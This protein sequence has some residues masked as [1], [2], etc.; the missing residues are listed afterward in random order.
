MKRTFQ[1]LFIFGVICATVTVSWSDIS[2][3]FAV[4]KVGTGLGAN[5][6]GDI[7]W[8][9]KTLW[10][11]GSG[12]LT[13]LIG[14]GHSVY[15]WLSYEGQ[16]GFGKGSIGALST[17]GDTLVASWVFNDVRGGESLVSGDGLSIS[18]DRGVTWRHVPVIELFPE[19]SDY[20]YPGTF[21]MTYDLE[22]VNGILWVASTSG[23]LFKTG[24]M[25]LTWTKVMPDT[26][27]LEFSNVN[28]HG[29]S[30]DVYG[31]TLWV[32]T[33]M[34]VNRSFDKGKTWTNYSWPR[35]TT[36]NP[37]PDKIWPG[38]WVYTI[39]HK[40]VNGKTHVWTSSEIETAKYGL[41]R[42]GICHTD[43]NGET[44]EY[45]STIYNAW[46]FAF[47]HDGANNPKISDET[48]IA[49]TDSG[50]VISYDLGENWKIIDISESE[51]KVWERGTQVS[52]VLA[53]EDTLWVTSSNGLARSNDWGESWE[54]F[55]GITRVK[56]LDTGKRD[57][58]I[59]SNL[60][61]VETYAFP[62]PFSPKRRDNDYT[63][64]RIQYSL[65]KGADISV[66]IYN[67]NGRLIKKLLE[68]EYRAGGR[69]YQESWDGTD[70]DNTIVPNGVYFYVIKTNKG[71]TARG[72]I[73]V[74]D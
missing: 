37:D 63:R 2:D 44:W 29:Y 22:L 43:D 3:M 59:S 8:D 32:G 11:S 41:G 15:D 60:D 52:G 24:N 71:D 23:F 56:T 31:D 14:D 67:Y 21:T 6:L 47:G 28:H 1:L 26:M 9:G 68:S 10:V 20:T 62:N 53:V 65:E 64:T 66:D 54:I 74:L 49:A 45:K 30:M 16:A 36:E 17:F 72:K 19:R 40:V 13:N 38:N 27:E 48:V 70:S 39:E 18:L 12:T 55:Q 46:N 35:D 25:G 50:L 34:G 61:N 58:G 73:M 33:Y 57:I 7:A 5:D 4:H 51:G 69:D 42:Y